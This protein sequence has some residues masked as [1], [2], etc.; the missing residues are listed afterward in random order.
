MTLEQLREEA[1]KD[2][3]H[4]VNALPE[5]EDG[6][7]L[8]DYIDSLITR[9]REATI[10]ECMGVVRGGDEAVGIRFHQG[11]LIGEDMRLS[12]TLA[13]LEVLKNKI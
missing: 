1:R 12:G 10:S 13:R 5:M 6:A 4:Y 7:D 9:V 2:I 8:I 11:S 3:Q